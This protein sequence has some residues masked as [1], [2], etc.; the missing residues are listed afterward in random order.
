MNFIYNM[1]EYIFKLS[2]QIDGFFVI[3]SIN[4]KKNCNENDNNRLI[5]YT[6]LILANWIIL[7]ELY[8]LIKFF[9]D[10]TIWIKDYIINSSYKTLWRIFQL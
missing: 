10:F 2:Y 5:W 9:Q 7:K 1:I 6:I 8:S 4:I 3:L